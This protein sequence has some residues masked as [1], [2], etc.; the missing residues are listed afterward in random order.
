M[1]VLYETAAGYALFKVIDESCLA[2]ADDVQAHFNSA[3]QASKT[4]IIP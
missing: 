1:L 2:N 4:Y 3:A